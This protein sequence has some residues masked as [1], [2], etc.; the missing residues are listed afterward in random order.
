MNTVTLPK[1][2]YMQILDTQ[3]KLRGDLARLQKVVSHIAQDEVSRDYLVRLS[4]I[5]RGLSDGKGTELKNKSEI[6]KFFFS[7]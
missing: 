5:E 6:K 3:E 7:L 4:K 2:K 1:N